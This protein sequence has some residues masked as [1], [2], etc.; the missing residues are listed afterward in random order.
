[1]DAVDLFPAARFGGVAV[2][3]DVA[4]ISIS[5]VLNTK[6]EPQSELPGTC[7]PSLGSDGLAVVRMPF[8]MGLSSQPADGATEVPPS[9]PLRLEF[10][11][12]VA[13]AAPET[14]RLIRQDGSVNGV[15]EPAD[16]Q[17]LG[18][19]VLLL[20]AQPLVPSTTY[21]VV[22]DQLTD[23][24]TQA[25]M[26]GP[27][28]LE[29]STASS[30]GAMPVSIAGLTPREGPAA[31]G[32]LVTVTGTGFESGATVRLGG[33]LATQVTVSEDGTSLTARTAA[34]TAGAATLEVA[35]PT[36]SVAR[37]WGAFLFTQPLSVLAATPGRGPASGGT[38]VLLSGTGFSSTGTVQVRFG[39]VPALRTRVLG[40]SR[41][42]VYTPR[43]LRG[44]VDI[45][46]TNPDGSQATL[47]DGYIFDQ[48]GGASVGLSERPVDVVV[49]GESA[50]VLQ[51][52]G[53]S[54]VDLS[55]LYLKGPLKDTPIPP[56]L[57]DGLVDADND[58][59]DDRLVSFTSIPDALSLAYPSTWGHRLYV[60]TGGLNTKEQRWTPGKVLEVTLTDLSRP[61]IA[62]STGVAQGPVF[63]L[64]VKDDRLLAATGEQGLS[65][66]DV[67][68]PPFLVGQLSM[69][70]P[71][72]CVAG[73]PGL[74]ALGVGQ[75]DATFAVSGGAL[76][77]VSTE[78]LPSLRGTLPLDVQRV[79]W[80]GDVAVVAAGRCGPGAGERYA[81]RISPRCWP[82]CQWEASPGTCGCRATWPTW[83][84]G[85][86]AWRWWT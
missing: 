54:V 74:A 17:T 81:A 33:V 41:L 26:A 6:G 76:R 3:R 4:V 35:N 86:R 70:G 60:G 29:F 38:R 21:R 62:A 56:D 37:R 58:R 31:G 61:V 65:S 64:D 23:A 8:L 7:Y 69:E 82:R 51:R 30:G 75:R 80:K 16:I 40:L 19:T 68:N 50:L 49:I 71:A 84:Q 24:L 47:E 39:G 32:T 77:L 42:E 2:E 79:K 1:M 25:E 43:G 45:Q 78:A 20:P 52:N 55:G 28:V 66:F 15:V 67:S 57:A 22:A 85:A 18:S 46:V 63:G 12:E 53:L 9:T 83:R 11:R 27:F 5:A 44:T 72:Q 48:P 14:V 73:S 59:K 36:G 34:N 10:N 13:G